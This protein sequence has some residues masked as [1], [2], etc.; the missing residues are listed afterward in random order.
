MPEEIKEEDQKQSITDKDIMGF[1]ALIADNTLNQKSD[2]DLKNEMIRELFAEAFEVDDATGT[3]KIG[4]K[5]LQQCLWRVMSKIKFLNFRIHITGESED[6]ERFATEG[7]RTIADRGNLI[8]CF[9]DKGG[10]FLNSF[11][12]GDGYLMMGKAKNDKN[13]ISFRVLNNEDVYVDNYAMGIRGTRPARKLCVIFGFSKEEAYAEWPELE[14]AGVFGR[15]PGTYQDEEKDKNKNR[16]DVLEVC[17]AWDLNK[18]CHIIFAGSEAY[19]LERYEEEEYPS[20]KNGEPFI[21]VFQF[22]CMPSADGFTNHGISD[23]IFQLAVVTR[24]LLNLEVGHLEE[25]VYPVTLINAPQSRVDELVEKMAMAYKARAVGKKP[26]VAMEF[27]PNGGSQQI[28]TQSLTTQGLFNEWSAVWDRLSREFSRLG[29]NIDDIERGS[30]YTRGQI[31][32]EEQASNAFVLQMMEYNASET[33]ELIECIIEAIKEYVTVKNKTPL[34][35]TTRVML[36]DGTSARLDTD[37][38]MGMLAKTLKDNNCF[39]ITDSRTG[40]IPSDLMRSIQM[41]QQLSITQ[42]GTPEYAQL[43]GRLAESR[44]LDLSQSATPQP[45]QEQQQAGNE[46]IPQQPAQTQRVLP[47]PVGTDLMPV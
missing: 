4:S 7:I 13:P 20:I 10:I 17:W 8:K 30:G 44:G 27:D 29:I 38:T 12:Y 36:E 40:A 14:E 25:N 45:V 22:S 21:P 41:E 23:M 2:R 31:I 15:I 18:K 1:L 42:P 19:E 11:L 46:V 35:L 37:I 32:A 6:T 34:N 16:E 24:K 43:W 33:Q 5:V 28:G 39:V 47:Q 9:R 3:K 26:F